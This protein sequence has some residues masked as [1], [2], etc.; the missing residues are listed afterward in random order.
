MTSITD[1]YA[2]T[3]NTDR[4]MTVV[5]TTTD[6]NS[7]VSMIN[8][9]LD[10]IA[11]TLNDIASALTGLENDLHAVMESQDSMMTDLDSVTMAQDNLGAS[12]M[13]LQSKIGDLSMMIDNLEMTLM[14]K[15]SELEASIE[16]A[17]A[18]ADRATALENAIADLNKLIRDNQAK[19]DE[20]LSAFEQSLNIQLT[21]LE[22]RLGVVTEDLDAVSEQVAEGPTRADISG[23]KSGDAKTTVTL[24]DYSINVDEFDYGDKEAK[25]TYNYRFECEETIYIDELKA[26]GDITKGDIDNSADT[27]EDYGLFVYLLGGTPATVTTTLEEQ[28]TI[29]KVAYYPVND[30]TADVRIPD[31]QLTDIVLMGKNPTVPAVKAPITLEAG[32][33]FIIE[34]TVNNALRAID[35]SG[36]LDDFELFTDTPPATTTPPTTTP[37]TPGSN[38]MDL[39]ESKV[40]ID[41]DSVDLVPAATNTPVDKM[42]LA[43]LNVVERDLERL[44]NKRISD[45]AKRVNVLEISVGWFSGAS[46]P[47]CTFTPVGEATIDYPNQ[48]NV[49]NVFA[50]IENIAVNASVTCNGVGT[51]IEDASDIQI[52]GAITNHEVGTLTFTAGGESIKLVNP[53]E[54]TGI[55]ELAN[56]DIDFPLEFTDTLQIT[57]TLVPETSP[58]S[59]IIQITYDT[60]AGNTC[61]QQ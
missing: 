45:L 9:I 34:T 47:K 30:T 31:V 4:L 48:D 46:D 32:E 5:D 58:G 60:A 23:A 16:N 50:P 56:S 38:L 3:T 25:F 12:Q 37:P 7:L 18:L 54:D 28:Y 1:A 26:T 24:Y 40:K 21:S 41:R 22:T 27:T 15:M 57:G 53:N 11:S 35:S 29:D 33:S 52:G 55:F 20:K 6:T 13:E 51:I 61:T 10:G 59:V 44:D 36:T 39:L 19:T 17:T 42:F 2:Q 49:L 8:M 14:T 43:G